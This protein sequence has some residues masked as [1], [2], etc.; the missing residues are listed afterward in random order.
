MRIPFG[1]LLLLGCTAA[2]AEVT[3]EQYAAVAQQT[4]QQRDQGVSLSRLLAE[5]ERGE[6]KERLTAQELATMR[7]VIRHSFNGTLSPAEVLE[8]CRQG[9]VLVPGR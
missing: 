4:V 8:A 2:A 9:G 3:C 7:E 1:F 6:M 5:T